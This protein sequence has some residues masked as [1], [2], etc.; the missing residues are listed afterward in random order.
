MNR[1]DVIEQYHEATM[2][3]PE[4]LRATLHLL[5]WANQPDPFREYEGTPIV[6]LP[7]EAP[8]PEAN[9][10]EL[11]RGE[12][13][14]ATAGG[15]LAISALLFHAAAVS[16]TKL[17]PAGTR[18]ALRVNP[19]SGNLH[20]TEFHFSTHG[21][22]DWPDGV[23]H[24]RAS[25]HV[26]EQRAAGTL[27]EEPLRFLL[28]TIVWRE[29]WK[30]RARAYRYCLLDAGHALEA[31][32]TSAR[33]LGWDYTLTTAF[34]DD[35]VA[36]QFRLPKDEWP[37]ALVTFDDV[38]GE[39]REPAEMFWMPGGTSGISAAIVYG[40][41]ERVH[42]ATK[43]DRRGSPA[44][45]REEGPVALPGS[46]PSAAGFAEVVRRRRSAVDFLGGDRAITLGQL[47]TVLRA[48]TACNEYIRLWLFMHRV[49]TLAPGVYRYEQYSDTLTPL[50]LGD[51]RVMAAALSLAQQLAGNS[52]VTFALTGRLQDGYR[53]VHL[54]AGRVGHRLY[55]AAEALGLQATGIGAF[56]D[57]L[58]AEYLGL[59]EAGESVLYHF[60]VGYAVEDGRVAPTQGMANA[61]LRIHA[62]TT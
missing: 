31:L 19:S 5:D 10:L 21:L 47:A 2:H 52:V 42:E 35:A 9:L 1:R 40:E 18:Y 30:Y 34:D 33:A 26:A 6:D 60:A 57:A 44:P 16:A 20:P 50:R 37:L 22:R 13:A 43:L 4:R 23:Y 11:L 28:T 7:G 32:V 12:T 56:H 14:A 36:E 41:I 29:A 49:E 55:L 39:P 3:T 48:A 61:T 51:Q 54:E 53:D 45:W 38:P 25:Q 58:V 24:Y 59:G 8:A 27:T 46:A 15:P 62:E 17:S